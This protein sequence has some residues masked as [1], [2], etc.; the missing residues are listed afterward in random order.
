MTKRRVINFHSWLNRAMGGVLLGCLGLFVSVIP[1]SKLRSLERV[2]ESARKW[3]EKMAEEKEHK[4]RGFPE[5]PRG[6]FGGF[7]VFHI[8][9]GRSKGNGNV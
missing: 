5:A 1:L 8:L 2:H 4:F 3:A 9:Y 6:L 7:L